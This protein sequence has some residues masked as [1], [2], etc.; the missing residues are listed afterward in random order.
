MSMD[1][2][3]MLLKDIKR[4]VDYFEDRPENKATDTAD[5]FHH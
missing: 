4:A 1:I 5:G 2:A 3:N